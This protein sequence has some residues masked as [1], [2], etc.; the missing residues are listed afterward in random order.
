VPAGITT[1]TATVD[2]ASGGDFVSGDSCKLGGETVGTLH[3]SPADV[4]TIAVGQKGADEG[5]ADGVHAYGGGRAGSVDSGAGGGGGSFVSNTSALLLAAGG[6]GGW[7]DVFGGG[8]G[9]GEGPERS[10]RWPLRLLR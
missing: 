7:G 3:V 5:N 2:G 8:T 6:G 1:L 4:L 10:S 9:A